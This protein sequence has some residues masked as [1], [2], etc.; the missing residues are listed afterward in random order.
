MGHTVADKHKA[1]NEVIFKRHNQRI[2]KGFNE[3]K[4]LAAE[5]DQAHLIP[6]NDNLPLR[7][8]CECSDENCRQRILLKPSEYNKLHKRRNRFVILP[9]H[10]TSRIEKVVQK[11][12][13]YYIVEK[14]LVPSVSKIDFNALNATDTNNA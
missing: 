3:I 7:F 4:R 5:D 2:Q 8:Y 9:G 11:A 10:E 6:K 13:K 1:E 12:D 14:S